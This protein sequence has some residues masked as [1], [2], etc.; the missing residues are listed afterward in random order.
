MA[1]MAAVLNPLMSDKL[2][3]RSRAAV[4]RFFSGL[5]LAEPGMV[6]ASQWRPSSEFEGGSPAALWAGVARKR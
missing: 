1:A 2:T 6:Q 4:A 5:E 3:F